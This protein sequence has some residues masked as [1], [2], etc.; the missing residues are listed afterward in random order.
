M[1]IVADV[2]NDVSETKIVSFHVAYNFSG[3]KITPAQ[4]VVYSANI[5]S[6][7]STN[8]LILPVYNPGNCVNNIIPLDFSK[9]SNFIEKIDRVYEQWFP[10]KQY[11]SLNNYSSGYNS[12]SK[13]EVHT[14]GDYKFSIMASKQDFDRINT[15][16]LNINPAAKMAV[17]V[18]T[19]NYSFIIYQFYKAGK[20]EVTPFGY[21]CRPIADD[22][23]ILP[24]IHG[25]PHNVGAFNLSGE[26]YG[27]VNQTYENSQPSN[28]N[29][30]NFADF[31]HEIYTLIKSSKNKQINV[32]ELIDIV[33]DINKDYRSRN[34]KIYLPRNSSVN[35]ITIKGNKKNRNLICSEDNYTF[36]D[37]IVNQ[38]MLYN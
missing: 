3:E 10:K 17:N 20:V 14:V 7:T 2:S 5:D 24:T 4:L 34:I 25:H 22:K 29:F 36:V 18:H 30:E 33:K 11:R 16:E 27:T 26:Y 37:D 8:A 31:D 13:L 21:L 15:N 23:M 1:C 9:L 35:K 38:S 19:D 12:L 28:E 6:A 32:N